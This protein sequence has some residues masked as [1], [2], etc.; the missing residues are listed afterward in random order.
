MHAK[1]HP[2]PPVARLVV[3]GCDKKPR[4]F[5]GCT[6]FIGWYEA[7][8]TLLNKAWSSKSAEAYWEKASAPKRRREELDADVRE[9]PA[10]LAGIDDPAYARPC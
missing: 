8:V 9:E 6:A 4:K 1:K 2:R 3:D 10:H 7:M 5:R